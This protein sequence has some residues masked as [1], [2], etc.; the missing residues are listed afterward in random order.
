MRRLAVSALDNPSVNRRSTSSSRLARNASSLGVAGAGLTARAKW[1]MNR[2][3]TD[4][5]INALPAAAARTP[6]HELFGRGVFEHESA[7][8]T[9]ERTVDMLVC[10]ER[11]EHDH[12]GGA[13]GNDLP[14]GFET[15]HHR[16]GTS[17]A[18]LWGH[19][20]PWRSSMTAAAPGGAR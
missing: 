5:S 18:L 3:V 6:S 20:R 10:V 11:G 8:P 9:L 13:V 2:L 19:L 17:M 4:A 7:R 1:A 15:V 16:H 14:R 12:P